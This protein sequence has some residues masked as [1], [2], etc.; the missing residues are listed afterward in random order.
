MTVSV[1][2]AIA[3]DVSLVAVCLYAFVRGGRPE[4]LGASI[5]LV[6]SILS[7]TARLSGFASWAPLEP[8]ILLIDL[9]VAFGFYKLAT[10]TTRFWPIW[11]FGFAL[12]DIFAG[13]A[14][15]FLPETTLIAYESG[16]GVYAYLAL[17]AL[18]IGCAR[19]PA[20]A[21]ETTR[22][23]ARRSCH[24]QTNRNESLS[25]SSYRDPS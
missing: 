19:L 2:L 6:G 18:A 3:Y 13:V 15:K 16:L 25:G 10:T 21:D 24:S 8:T 4:R 17:I 14:G 20:D 11:A 12:A 23:G 22:S 5:N 1:L 7:S 9:G